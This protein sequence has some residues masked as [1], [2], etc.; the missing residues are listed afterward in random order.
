[1]LAYKKLSGHRAGFA[2]VLSLGK[3]KKMNRFTLVSDPDFIEEMFPLESKS[4]TRNP[5]NYYLQTNEGISR[6]VPLEYDGVPDGITKFENSKVVAT[7][8][9]IM[10]YDEK[11]FFNSENSA[12][13]LIP[14]GMLSSTWVL[15]AMGKYK[16]GNRQCK[17]KWAKVSR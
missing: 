1:L 2:K 16:C 9:A 17:V 7:K 6:V 5:R 14:P 13:A 10:M 12:N 3:Q 15:F 8:L 11:L 4:K